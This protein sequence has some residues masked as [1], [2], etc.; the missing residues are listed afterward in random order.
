MTF[1]AERIIIV[2]QSGS[3]SLNRYIQCHM[4]TGTADT[5]LAPPVRPEKKPINPTVAPTPRLRLH[6]TRRIRR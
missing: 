5:P 3:Y 6:L 1:R 2:R 4:Y